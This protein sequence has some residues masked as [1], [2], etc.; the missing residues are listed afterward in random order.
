[1]SG[2]LPYTLVSVEMNV[3]KNVSFNASQF[4]MKLK[5]KF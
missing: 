1:M 4:S 3:F 2:E 5:V